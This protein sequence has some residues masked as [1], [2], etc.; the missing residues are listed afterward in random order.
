MRSV[1]EP[2]DAFG[3]DYEDDVDGSSYGS[4][5][6]RSSPTRDPSVE[7]ILDRALELLANKLLLA[8]RDLERTEQRASRSKMEA[9]NLCDEFAAV[10]AEADERAKREAARADAAVFAA[11]NAEARAT[12][13]EARAAAAEAREA[14]ARASAAAGW[15]G[16]SQSAELVPGVATYVLNTSETSAASSAREPPPHAAPAPAP[17]SALVRA[18]GGGRKPAAKRGAAAN[19]KAAKTKPKALPPPAKGKAKPRRK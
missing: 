3:E 11:A 9:A 4:A 8:G 2:L 10:A 19:A 1:P 14:G 13:A 15:N 17:A 6:A 5:E 18:A 16:D 7:A 12:A